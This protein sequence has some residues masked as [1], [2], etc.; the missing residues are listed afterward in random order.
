M[1]NLNCDEGALLPPFFM[2]EPRAFP[3]PNHFFHHPRLEFSGHASYIGGMTNIN[4]LNEMTFM[5]T[6]PLL[7]NAFVA[8]TLGVF[9]IPSTF[10]AQ[11]NDDEH[12]TH[13]GGAAALVPYTGLAQDD[14]D[15]VSGG[16]AGGAADTTGAEGNP[17]FELPDELLEKVFL[18]L[19]VR[20]AFFL[21]ETCKKFNQH[22]TR[23][24]LTTI[25]PEPF[26]VGQLLF[27]LRQTEQSSLFGNR[28]LVEPLSD[29][30]M[31][32][33]VFREGLQILALTRYTHVLPEGL[34]A[35][36]TNLR[37]LDLRY[38]TQPLPEGVF[39]GATNLTD[40]DLSGYIGNLDPETFNGLT[41]LRSLDLSGYARDIPEGIFARL[42]SLDELNI[43]HYTGS[44]TSGVFDG[45]GNITLLSL[46]S[47]T[48]N[49]TNE[50]FSGLRSLQL[51]SI[52]D[53]SGILPDGFIDNLRER[54]VHSI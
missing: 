12:V 43:N 54:G 35:G 53:H 30:S 18:Y 14:T 7:R 29:M 8:L 27:T 46:N 25:L 13:G 38:H 15:Q 11:A 20:G 39:D 16:G 41:D 3:T 24:Y 33:E 28:M 42:G 22:L 51:L 44:L 19:D 32:P 40:L 34:L 47:Y 52:N 49:L 31:S 37:T 1:K 10:A 6:M 5:N 36:V 17:F 2:P 26:K 4:L 9:L 50:V 23:K 48:G 21:K 45:L